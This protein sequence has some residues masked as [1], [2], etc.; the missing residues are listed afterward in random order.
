VYF[1]SITLLAILVLLTSTAFAAGPW[2]RLDAPGVEIWTNAGE[3][4]ARQALHSIQ[5]IRQILLAVQPGATPASRTLR[6]V[7]FRTEAE[8]D[9]FRPFGEPRA[10]AFYLEGRQYDYIVM[11]GEVVPGIERLIFHEYLHVFSRNQNLPVPHWFA[12][13]LSELF[14]NAQISRSAISIGDTIP[15]HV[16]KLLAAGD[17]DLATLFTPGNDPLFYPKSWA[18]VRLLTLQPAHRPHLADFLSRVSKGEPHSVAFEEAFGKSVAGLAKDLRESLTGRLPPWVIKTSVRVEDETARPV[19]QPPFAADLVIADLLASLE[20]YDEAE[21]ILT[22][23]AKDHDS[24]AIE[25][26]LALISL[27]HG[28]PDDAF[29]HYSQAIQLGTTDA[30]IYFDRAML[31]RDDP[32][33]IADL[34]KAVELNPDYTEAYQQLNALTLR[35]QTPAP[36]KPGSANGWKNR[37]GDRRVD[38]NLIGLDC[39][40]APARFLLATSQGP[41]SLVV[42]DPSQVVIAN[43]PGVSAELNCGVM[44]PRPVSVEY[45]AASKEIT[46]IHFK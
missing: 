32:S 1:R 4:K 44:P 24:A 2:L 34:R 14:S 38:G 42:T 25:S 6:L 30:R 40:T 22:R 33:A 8:F 41:L 3:A 17:L 15:A 46:A 11:S 26:Q 28:N 7:L 19:I 31:H 12:E 10:A 43:D 35:L 29:H 18:L 27:R 9:S 36:L 21:S 23:L 39:S 20:R 16:Q 5:Q 45:I 37:T 13:G